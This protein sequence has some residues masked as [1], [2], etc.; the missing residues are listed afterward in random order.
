MS[1]HELRDVIWLDPEQ[2]D[3][4]Q[5]WV[6]GFSPELHAFYALLFDDLLDEDYI[7]QRW[8]RIWPG[9]TSMDEPMAPVEMWVAADLTQLDWII[10]YESTGRSIGL[11]PGTEPGVDIPPDVWEE[12]QEEQNRH[13]ARPGA[14]AGEEPKELRITGRDITPEI[15]GALRR[16]QARW[17]AQR[18]AARRAAAKE[19]E[20]KLAATHRQ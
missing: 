19:L 11:E 12:L 10:D 4:E 20:A 6:Y 3:E 9:A 8:G 7:L 17:A 1:A 16:E 5:C 18:A 2:P 13:R 15:F 14:T